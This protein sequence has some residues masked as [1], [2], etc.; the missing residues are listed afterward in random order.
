MIEYT[1]LFIIHEIHDVRN[2][3]ISGR[4]AHMHYWSQSVTKLCFNTSSNS[5][6]TLAVLTGDLVRVISLR[7]QNCAEDRRQEAQH[8]ESWCMRVRSSPRRGGT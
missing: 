2:W 4:L 6:Y 1:H 8:L 7:Q 3:S 5:Y